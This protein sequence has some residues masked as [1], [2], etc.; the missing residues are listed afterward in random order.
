MNLSSS[1]RDGAAAIKSC[2]IMNQCSQDHPLLTVY[3]VKL[4][5]CD[6]VDPINYEIMKRYIVFLLRG[7]K[8]PHPSLISCKEHRAGAS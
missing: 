4:A 1:T 5:E 6:L 8:L 3:E 7:V 2:L